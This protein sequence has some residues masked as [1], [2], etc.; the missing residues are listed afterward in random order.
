MEN[1]DRPIV[2]HVVPHTHW[3]RA[4]Y[5]PFERFRAGLPMLF[6]AIFA[7][8]ADPG[9]PPFLLDGQTVMIDDYLELRPGMREKLRALAAAGRLSIGPFYVQA[10]VMLSHPEAIVR[11]LLIGKREAERLGRPARVGYFP[12][13][14]GLPR[15]L[16]QIL[17]DFGARA[18]VFGRGFKEDVNETGVEFNYVGLDGSVL[19][20]AFMPGGYVNGINLGYAGKWGDPS[21]QPFDGERAIGEVEKATA[22]L[23]GATR[24]GHAL[25]M[26]GGD[27]EMPDPRLASAL[28][29]AAARSGIGIDRGGIE[30]YAEAIASAS[31]SFPAYSEDLRYGR[32]SYMVHGTTSARAYLKLRQ[33]RSSRRLVSTIEPLASTLAL[34]GRPI[35]GSLLERAWKILLQNLAHDEIGGCSI[36]Q[37]HR[38]MM[39]RYDAI[40]QILDA[41]EDECALAL[42]RAARIDPGMGEARL[43]FNACAAPTEG[44]TRIELSIDPRKLDADDLAAFDES[45][46]PIPFQVIGRRDE[47]SMRVNAARSRA[48]VEAAIDP[49]RMEPFSFGTIYL[50]E[51]GGAARPAAGA[52]SAEASADGSAALLENEIVSAEFK[53]GAIELRDK[54]N[55]RSFADFLSLTDEADS[56]DEYTFSPLDGDVPAILR[57]EGAFAEVIEEGPLVASVRL[58]GS[59]RAPLRLD[60]GRSRRSGE[61]SA[62]E[63]ELVLELRAGSPELGVRARLENEAKD[64]RMRLRFSLRGL[65]SSSHATGLHYGERDRPNEPEAPDDAGWKESFPRASPFVGYVSASDRIGGIVIASDDSREYEFSPGPLVDFT[66]F[67]GVGDLSREDLTTRRGGA[68]FTFATPDA[69]CLGPMDFRFGARLCADP[70]ECRGARAYRAAES[71]AGRVLA[72][73][74]SEVRGAL[75]GQFRHPDMPEGLPVLPRVPAPPEAAPRAP[76]R[77]V[78][79]DTVVCAF[80]PAESR[81][82]SVL[83]V[84]NYSP[85]PM[86]ARIEIDASIVARAMEA[87]LSEAPGREVPAPDGLVRLALRPYG[88]ATLLL[89]GRSAPARAA[90]ESTGSSTRPDA[91][92]K[93]EI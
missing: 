13:S 16:P 89:E 78:T 26:N 36:D 37:V 92:C 42:A 28:D 24:S 5:L 60:R 41:A 65:D 38:E 40:D 10:E 31:S 72:F 68:G 20:F 44:P 82:G 32:Y 88:L 81:G 6:E 34:L 43:L 53:D 2:A 55:G 27:H 51:G 87:K 25:V 93:N 61:T 90:A 71:M 49:G 39:S 84:L 47:Y 75:P 12:D 50:R 8:L 29:G 76:F 18:A 69:Q 30:S 59:W 63:Y 83:R 45:G 4:W 56:G 19:P 62:L 9:N 46:E 23:A 3:D 52:A 79:E 58:R 21:A 35:E 80:K 33:A 70:E 86:E 14:W 64:H 15:Q 91:R 85:E 1:A 17:L 57:F 77:V 67:R 74:C 7:F 73:D 48:K 66:L 11:N 54:R 22:D